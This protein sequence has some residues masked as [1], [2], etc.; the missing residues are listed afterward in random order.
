MNF[1][2]RKA[3][4]SASKH[5]EG[6]LEIIPHTMEEAFQMG[7]LFKEFQNND[8]EITRGSHDMIRILIPL[9]KA[10]LRLIQ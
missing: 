7:L 5:P 4:D 6:S 3:G 8:L 2:I 9:E 10:K 1:L